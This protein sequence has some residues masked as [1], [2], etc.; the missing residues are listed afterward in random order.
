MGKGFAQIFGKKTFFF[1]KMEG[2]NENWSI[3]F[4][5]WA[6][7]KSRIWVVA[8]RNLEVPEPNIVLMEL[9]KYPEGWH[10]E[11]NFKRLGMD[12]WIRCVEAG[13]FWEVE[14]NVECD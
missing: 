1:E 6:D 11:R 12:E 7:A 10:K 13:L 8:D 4:K 9:K 3:P 2:K 5:F 14:V